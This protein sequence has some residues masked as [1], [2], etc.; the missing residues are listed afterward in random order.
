MYFRFCHKNKVYFKVCH[1]N[2]FSFRVCHQDIVINRVTSLESQIINQYVYLFMLSF[3]Y[4]H[5]VI[6]PH[7]AYYHGLF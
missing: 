4:L 2:T 7:D 5:I 3:L 1:Q 6:K